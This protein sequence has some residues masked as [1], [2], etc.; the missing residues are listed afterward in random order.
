MLVKNLLITLILKLKLIYLF[1]YNLLDLK[2]NLA[3]YKLL[4]KKLLQLVLA[5]TF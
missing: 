4:L 3:F 5:A 1:Y 2:T